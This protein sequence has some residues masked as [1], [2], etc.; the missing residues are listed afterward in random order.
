MEHL[1]KL[2]II[3][4]WPSSVTYFIP[5]E[6]VYYYWC[7]VSSLCIVLSRAACGLLD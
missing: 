2:D 1:K 4:S 7:I 5:F 3:I 6:L